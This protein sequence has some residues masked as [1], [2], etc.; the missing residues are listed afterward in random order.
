MVFCSYCNA[1]VV[2]EV[3]ETN[4][5]SCC[6]SCGR[7][8]DDNIFSTDPTFSKGAGG[9]SQVDG[10]FVALDGHVGSTLSRGGH[11]GIP[12]VFGYQVDS[13]EKT[14]SKGKY[15]ISQVAERLG[16]RPREDMINAAHRIYKLA[17]LRNFTR[18]RR[19]AQVAGA[20][21]YLVCRQE[22]K[23]YML[24]D[25][26]DIL[27]T[28][29]YVLGSV[30][31]QLCRLLRLEKHP[32]IQK[33]ID[34]SLFIHRFADRLDFG[35]KMHAVANT[36]L[37]LVASMKRD[38]MQTGRLPNGIC[39]AA[40]FI[41]THTHG[42]VRTKAEVVGVVHVCEATLKKRLDEFGSTPSSALTIEEFEA[43]A[44]EL[45]HELKNSTSGDRP[46]LLTQ[47]GESPSV[48]SEG[49]LVAL[50]GV[51]TCC[52][53]G[54]AGVQHFA[55]GLCRH[56]Y[57][58]FLTVSGGC[59]GDSLPPAFQRAEALRAEQ[60][61]KEAEETEAALLRG[62]TEVSAAAS[63]GTGPESALVAFTA[64]G[65][66]GT[67]K[68]G[69][70]RGKRGVQ[71]GGGGRKGLYK[72]P[73]KVPVDLASEM[74]RALEGM[75]A[76]LKEKVSVGR[77]GLAAA[78]D[79][80]DGDGDGEGEGRDVGGREGEAEGR[81]GREAGAAGATAT[82]GSAR[83]GARVAAG[84]DGA[85][86]SADVSGGRE[87]SGGAGSGPGDGVH[88]NGRFA[89]NG[90]DASSDGGV[91]TSGSLSSASGDGASSVDRADA[92][93]GGATVGGGSRGSMVTDA[94]AV[95]KKSMMSLLTDGEGDP[96]DGAEREGVEDGGQA[97]EGGRGQ[98][99]AKGA[100]GRDGLESE[101]ARPGHEPGGPH[102]EEASLKDSRAML[103]EGEDGAEEGDGEREPADGAAAEDE[104]ESLRKA[105][106]VRE[107]VVR[108]DAEEDTLS[109]IDDDELDD[110]INSHQEVELK[111]V[112]WSSMN[113]DYLENLAA[114]EAAIAASEAAQAALRQASMGNDGAAM[115][116]TAQAAELAAAA[117]VR[118]HKERKRKAAGA[119]AST[120]ASSVAAAASQMLAKKNLSS[121]VNYSALVELFDNEPGFAKAQSD[122]ARQTALEQAQAEALAKAQ[123][124]ALE[125][126]AAAKPL[127]P[128]TPLAAAPIKPSLKVG[129]FTPNVDKRR[130]VVF[131]DEVPARA[132]P[133]RVAAVA[134]PGSKVSEAAAAVLAKTPELAAVSAAKAVKLSD[135]KKPEVEVEEEE[136]EEEE[137]E[138][139]EAEDVQELHGAS[140]VYSLNYDVMEDDY[141]DE[142]D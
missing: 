18:G 84:R 60:Q 2:A 136:V 116:S 100:S 127:V 134:G 30:F 25:F 99:G 125:A 28:N 67:V 90:A 34:P 128:I 58:E 55:L 142:Y 7:V 73:K 126:D 8:L 15:E 117:V 11:G 98:G 47:A 87:G 62:D 95:G 37:R 44:K 110:Y 52:H 88:V 57:T 54:D 108:E 97:G 21:L 56:C 71:P 42:F 49:A 94:R 103:P 106:V 36:A 96:E 6:T 26:S 119:N 86:V 45:E 22:S 35:R 32:I 23:P 132:T 17:I 122:A 81:E 53:R 141:G 4:G 82:A 69:K 113:R 74:D 61:Q 123:A 64:G 78:L 46:L 38:W 31:L 33:P 3:D 140:K 131:E 133:S 19:T 9:A 39:G 41:A 5:F 10:N 109:D 137:E 138:E 107:E 75:Q 20:C 120:P 70:G 13:H 48:D 112:I 121:K 51:V 76:T 43:N 115:D 1:D 72:N 14:L 50:E 68:P 59:V 80:G 105:L 63:A 24:I 91:L 66:I 129:G 79:D 118:L 101:V 92:D 102:G 114:K 111:T 93:A 85:A 83:A 65:Q 29:V 104:E 130:R 135:A 77:V 40:L 27:Q 12:R 139:E 124:L 89:G 16:V